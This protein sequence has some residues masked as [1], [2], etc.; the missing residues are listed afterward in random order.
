M[1]YRGIIVFGHDGDGIFG[2]CIT[3]GANVILRGDGN[4]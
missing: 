1:V 2:V 3:L 4:N